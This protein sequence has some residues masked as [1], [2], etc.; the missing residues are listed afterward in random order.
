MIA[1]GI[2]EE[3][4]GKNYFSFLIEK[5]LKPLG[6]TKTN[7]STTESF[8]SENHTLGYHKIDEDF[9][10]EI[11]PDIKNFAGGAG[12]I[13]SCLKDMNKWI[14]FHI[15]KGKVKNKQLI[16]EK[17]LEKLY[18]MQRLDQNPFSI[19]TPGKNYV[20]CYGYA[21]GWWSIN[22]RGIEMRQ[23]I[24]TG[25]GII[26]NGGFMPEEDLGYILFS[27]TSGSDIPFY[28]N[29]DFADQMLG[30]ESVNW[31]KKMKE[32]EEKLAKNNEKQQK[33]NKDTQRE[34]VAPSH[35]IEDFIGIYHHQGYGNLEF[36]VQNNQLHCKFGEESNVDITHHN[37][38][39][40]IIDI[41][42]LGGFGVKKYVSFRDNFEG[43]ISHL[44]CNAE[45]LLE[46]AIFKKINKQ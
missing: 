5:F 42:T 45:P 21:L 16:S 34:E 7:F 37:Y 28:L 20:L 1:T 36:N 4:T 18:V 23:H 35:L 2:I 15:N 29:F 6:M 11:Y 12:C 8:K 44:E 32:F 40:Y 41:K 25:P 10:K 3:I 31:G 19:I 30:L 22:Y 13:N 27:N 39:T 24:G 38:N 26:F 43:E 46:P 33:S 9:E 17:T 14:Q